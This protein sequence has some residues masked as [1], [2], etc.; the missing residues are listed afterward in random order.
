MRIVIAGAGEVGYHIASR[1]ATEHKDVVVIDNNEAAIQKV[2]NNL[3]VQAILGSCSDPQ[4][5]KEAQI[6]AADLFLAVTNKDEINITA[7]LIVNM[8]SERTYKLARLRDE[9]FDSITQDLKLNSPYIDEIINPEEELVNTIVS[10]MHVPNSIEVKEFADSKLKFIG[11]K[12]DHS[13]NLLGIKFANFPEIFKKGTPLIGA[14]SR[15][16]EIIVPNGNSYLMSGDTVYFICKKEELNNILDVFNKDRKKIKRVVIIGAGETG[17]RLA[18]KVASQGIYTKI[19]EKNL[20]R[21]KKIAEKLDNN[22]IILNGDGSDS[23]LLIEENIKEYDAVITV[24]DKDETNILLSLL[25][26]KIGVKNTIAKIN[27]FNYFNILAPLGI[28]QTVSAKLSAIDTILQYVRRGNI[29][30][31]ITISREQAEVFEIKIDSSSKLAG[32]TIAKASIPKDTII[33]AVI[34]NETTIVPDG[35]TVLDVGDKVVMLAASS[36]VSKLEKVI[37]VLKK[38]IN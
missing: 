7:C 21:C 31:A 35:T 30:S 19:I 12:I 32:K 2:S 1:L 14:I 4:I 34:K 28:T 11:L 37:G 20:T 36:S 9:G 5:L 29:L 15:N 25:A 24:T 22:I 17:K 18:A 38:E 6:K 16:D 26:K 3:D 10:L 23:S 13:S 27:N 8:F 33:L